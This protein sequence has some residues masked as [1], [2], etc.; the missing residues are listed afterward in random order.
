MLILHLKVISLFRTTDNNEWYIL[1]HLEQDVVVK[2]LLKSFFFV[3]SS[4][5]VSTRHPFILSA[6][7]ITQH[8]SQSSKISRLLGTMRNEPNVSLRSSLATRPASLV[9]KFKN[10]LNRHKAP[11]NMYDSSLDAE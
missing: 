11:K 1:I 6:N 7:L 10:V 4:N 8:T 2:L 3:G 5:I 9:N